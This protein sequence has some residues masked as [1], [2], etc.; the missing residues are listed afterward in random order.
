MYIKN[1]KLWDILLVLLFFFLPKVV[2][3][4]CY[5]KLAGKCECMLMNAGRLFKNRLC[6]GSRSVMLWLTAV[7]SIPN[8][9]ACV[10]EQ[11]SVELWNRLF[12]TI[13]VC[14]FMCLMISVVH[15]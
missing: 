7:I 10:H 8:V 11:A 1:Y 2:T 14:C 3:A 9:Y 15:N 6:M 5:A 12:V 4:T 13:I